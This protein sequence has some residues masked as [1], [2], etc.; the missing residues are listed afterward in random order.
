MKSRVKK[1]PWA[2]AFLNFVLPGAGYLYLGKRKLFSAF[3]IV[4]LIIFGMWTYSSPQMEQVYY[5][6]WFNLS[7]LLIMLGFAIDAYNDAKTP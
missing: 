5:N 3:L 2:A 4:G 1:N 6:V 7:S